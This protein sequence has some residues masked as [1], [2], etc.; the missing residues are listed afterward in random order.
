MLFRS[1]LVPDERFRPALRERLFSDALHIA[2]SD[3][4]QMVA[5]PVP[6]RLLNWGWYYGVDEAALARFCADRRGVFVEGTLAPGSMSP[7]TMRLVAESIGVWSGPSRALADDVLASDCV[8]IHP[9]YE[10]A[11]PRLANGAAC[12]VGDAA[13]LASPITGAGGRLAMIDAIVLADALEQVGPDG[14]AVAARFEQHRLAESRAVV[15]AG[16][17]RGSVFRV[18]ERSRWR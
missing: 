2:V 13:H 12:L 3:G 1:H 4:H 14:E 15:G 7:E 9:I 5:Y 6:G 18:N 10:Y 11:S 16:R 17:Q 8:A